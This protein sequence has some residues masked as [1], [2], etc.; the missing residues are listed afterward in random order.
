MPSSK[1]R[2]IDRERVG[3]HLAELPGP[4]EGAAQ[5]AEPAQ[6]AGIGAET[7]LLRDRTIDRLHPHLEANGHC[8][9]PKRKA[10]ARWGG[11]GAVRIGMDGV[12]SVADVDAADA[13]AVEVQTTR[14]TM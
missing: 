10:P 6:M 3:R 13:L 4:R 1:P 8:T 9:G 7:G 14:R 5:A 11:A 12:R 2:A